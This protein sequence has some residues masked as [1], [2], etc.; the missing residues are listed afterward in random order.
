[1]SF[2]PQHSHQPQAY[3]VAATRE[4]IDAGLRS[5]MLR[6]YNYMALGVA[7]T[8]IVALAV[9]STPAL[10]QTIAVGPFK[11]VLFIGIIGLG[12]FAPRVILTGSTITGHIAFWVYAAMWGALIAPMFY[13]Y[14]GDSIARVFFIT[15]GAFAGLSLYGYTTKRDLA[16]MGRFLAMATIGILIA[17]LVNMFLLK[18][19]GFHTILS[20]VVVLV[21]AA[22][23]A[24][25]T[26]AIK[27]SYF[28]DD[29][30]DVQ[31][32]KA[33]FGAFILYGSFITLFIW[34]LHLF[35]NRE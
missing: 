24:Y 6:V 13:V 3:G 15:S 26:Q 35:G 28:E 25:E 9:A 34:L 5:Y 11:W 30:H 1:M 31:S 7:F 18:S 21:F 2:D 29:S 27:E 23:T 19:G 10:M 8:G 4:E 32:K 20:I 33:V 12:W 17:L 22:L 16:P 14:T